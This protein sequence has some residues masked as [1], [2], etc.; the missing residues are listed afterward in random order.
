MPSTLSIPET[1]FLFALQKAVAAEARSLEEPLE[2]GCYPVDIR[3]LIS[4][5]GTLEQLPEQQ[6]QSTPKICW[7]AAVALLLTQLK[8]SRPDSAALVRDALDRALSFGADYPKT[9]GLPDR[10][11]DVEQAAKDA[12]AAAG[13]IPDS[14]AGALKWSGEFEVSG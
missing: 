9:R 1:T 11:R 6:Y 12:Q 10:I 2:P 14:R 7:P 8:V 13:K 3:V 4:L 5:K